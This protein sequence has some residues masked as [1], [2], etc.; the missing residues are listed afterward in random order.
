M[1]II[2][3]PVKDNAKLLLRYPYPIVMF[4]IFILAACDRDVAKNV[5]GSWQLDSIYSFYNG[6]GYTN[7][8]VGEEP[9]YHFQTDGRLRMTKN[10]E[11]RYFQFTLLNDTLHYQNPSM[12]VSEK[13]FVMKADERQ[14]VLRK[15]KKVL[16]TGKDQQRFEIKYF[17]RIQN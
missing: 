8:D 2:D 12:H 3:F 13:Y 7:T 9:R 10:T 17:S 14:L 16:F 11:Y 1:R 4:F 15:E 5:Q 6:F